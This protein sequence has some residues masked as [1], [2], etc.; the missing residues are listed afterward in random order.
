MHYAV[1]IDDYVKAPFLGCSEWISSTLYSPV[2]YRS[3][4]SYGLGMPLS[5][6]D[7]FQQRPALLKKSHHSKDCGRFIMQ[8]KKS[9]H[10]LTFFS[11]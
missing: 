10:L 9:Q 11:F 3:L 7:N 5:H 1:F 2:H 6:W 4:K 8:R